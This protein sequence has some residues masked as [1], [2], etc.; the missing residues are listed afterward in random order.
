[1]RELLL[2]H[3]QPEDRFFISITVL[4]ELYFA[5]YASRRRT[6]NLQNINYLLDH[7]PLLGFDVPAAGEYGRIKAELKAK[8][9]PIPGTDAQIAAVARLHG[10]TVLSADHHFQYVDNLRAESWL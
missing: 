3:G 1:M 9:R 10:L 4:S 2:R 7:I 8:G 6:Q 5:A